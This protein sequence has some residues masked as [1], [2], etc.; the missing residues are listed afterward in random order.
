MREKKAKAS[1]RLGL[2]PRYL[3]GRWGGKRWGKNKIAEKGVGEQKPRRGKKGKT[4]ID[5]PKKTADGRT[6]DEAESKCGADQAERL[7]ALFG[8]SHVG[9]VGEGCSDVRSGDAGNEPADEKPAERGSE[10]H[11]DVVNGESE[12]GDENDGAAAEAV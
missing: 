6:N 10:S 2:G 11:K 8:R 1:K 3:G 5:T 9:D 12:A 4:K 7:G